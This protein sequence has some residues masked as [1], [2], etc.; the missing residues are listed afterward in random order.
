MGLG[1]KYRK[2]RGIG[3]RGGWTGL[4]KNIGRIGGWGGVGDGRVWGGNIRRGGG[5]G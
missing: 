3:R 2:E 5:M 4:G 1:K